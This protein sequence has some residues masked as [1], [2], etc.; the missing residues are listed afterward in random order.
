MGLNFALMFYNYSLFVNKNKPV[1]G[2][3]EPNYIMESLWTMSVV[4]LGLSELWPQ[5]FLLF[6]FVPA[7]N[8][9]TP[10]FRPLCCDSPRILGCNSIA[11]GPP[12]HFQNSTIFVG[13]IIIKLKCSNCF[14]CI[15]SVIQKRILKS[16][17]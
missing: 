4:S 3:Q 11:S 7:P 13:V 5:I 12:C 6:F 2:I 17:C 8:I 16:S 1:K 15:N 9:R 14:K 10:L